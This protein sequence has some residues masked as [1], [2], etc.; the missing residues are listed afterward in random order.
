MN[1]DAQT[2]PDK[3]LVY[4]HDEL[5]KRATA[6]FLQ[7]GHEPL[8]C[9]CDYCEN[10]TF[11]ISTAQKEEAIKNQFLMMSA[12]DLR[13]LLTTLCIP[14]HVKGSHDKAP[15]T[16][17]VFSAN[18]E[19]HPPVFLATLS[20]K[21]GTVAEYRRNDAANARVEPSAIRRNMLFVLDTTLVPNG[22][23]T[24]VSDE[25]YKVVLARCEADS[26]V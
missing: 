1:V 20:K 11:S 15:W 6:E 7:E 9:D 10:G 5:L 3:I 19:Q 24:K 16:G 13:A 17:I 4:L 2:L 21:K 25:V 12:A 26:K 22:Y 23:V 14:A 8:K 18:I